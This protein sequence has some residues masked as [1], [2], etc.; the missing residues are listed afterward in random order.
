MVSDTVLCMVNTTAQY[1]SIL[2]RATHISSYTMNTSHGEQYTQYAYAITKTTNTSCAACS[3]GYPFPCTLGP[4]IAFAKH[5]ASGLLYNI[6]CPCHYPPMACSFFV[7]DQFSSCVYQWHTHAGKAC[8]PITNACARCVD[9]EKKSEY[10]SQATV[11]GDHTL[12][13]M[14]CTGLHGSGSSA[15]PQEPMKHA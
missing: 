12:L 10:P 9:L 5:R 1:T 11:H 15:I 8:M 2:R 14:C 13:C 3:G 6:T 4:G 7:S